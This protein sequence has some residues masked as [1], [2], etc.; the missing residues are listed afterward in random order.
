MS[1]KS[2]HKWY[3]YQDLLSIYFVLNEIL[4]ISDSKFIF[5]TKE[6]NEDK[7]DDLTIITSAWIY[8]KQFKHS[9]DKQLKKDYIANDSN[10]DLWLAS[11]YKS[12]INYPKQD[13]LKEL[14]ICTTWKEPSAE[15]KILNFI[16]IAPW[17]IKSFEN[18]ITY[19][20]DI[21]KIWTASW[22][23]ESS[24]IKLKSE[25]IANDITRAE[26]KLFLDKLVI[27][28]NLPDFTLDL[29][30]PWELETI[31][32]KQINDIG[33]GI[34]PNNEI[35]D[36]ETILNLKEFIN[37]SRSFDSWEDIVW[38]KEIENKIWIKKDYGSIEQTF[39]IIEAENI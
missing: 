6:Y 10:Y 15:E 39:P 16:N 2:A 3:A 28:I 33:V 25:I 17:C 31:I 32:L 21:E 14:R 13:E 24:W 12:Y 1:L 9:N 23:I 27:E 38:I 34:Y 36:K 7:F 20:I 26:F 29:Y 30:S 19:S 37:K 11:L 5:D 8:K 4:N 22:H 18:S 35:S